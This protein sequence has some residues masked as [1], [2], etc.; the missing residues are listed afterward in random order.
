MNRHCLAL[1][2]SLAALSLAPVT[3]A[4]DVVTDWNSTLRAVAQQDGTHPVNK[5][6]P[7]WSTR[8]IAM[9]NGAIYDAFQATNRTH[10]PYLV[11]TLA[12]PNTS[13]D[14][15]VH[16]AAYEL[17]LQCYPGEQAM[18]DTDYSARMGSIP[19]G[20]D[21]TNGMNL[22]HSIALAYMAARTGDHADESF[23]YT[24]GT[25]P[26]QWRPDP[27]KTSSARCHRSPP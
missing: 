21:K 18:I 27:F 24:P 15:A 11:N 17:L 19:S 26:G 7:G 14:A 23:P 4:A 8:S 22:G 20:I 6:N 3:A 5:A 25:G 10:F 9:M 1:A 12:P 13:L 2:V 16:Q